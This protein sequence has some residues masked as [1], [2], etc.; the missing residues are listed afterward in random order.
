M[1]KDKVLFICVHNT[2]RSQLAEEL[3]RK[4]GGDL[5]EVESAGFK[6]EGEINPLVVE[7]LKEEGID[8]SGKKTKAL[9]DLYKQGRIYQY[10]VTVCDGSEE[11]QCPVFPGMTYRLHLP[12]P[13]P[14]KLQGSHE[15][16]LRKVRE[17]RDAI[18]A[19]VLEFMAWAK[20]GGQDVLT[21]TWKVLKL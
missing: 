12:F 16:K 10:V 18:R 11:Q 8:I 6:P 19:K 4:H 1:A 5:F 9:M 3:L 17:I 13:D 14:S 7:V 20:S 15:E 2:A 21:D